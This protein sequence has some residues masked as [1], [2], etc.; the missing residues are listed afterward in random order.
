MHQ[1]CVKA[2]FTTYPDINWYQDCIT[3]GLDWGYEERC[4]PAEEHAACPE[5]LSLCMPGVAV[6]DC[7]LSKTALEFVNGSQRCENQYVHFPANDFYPQSVAYCKSFP[8]NSSMCAHG[9]LATTECPD[10][11]DEVVETSCEH[12]EDMYGK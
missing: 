4:A 8:L 5:D 6:D 1:L 2:F 11:L 3:D 10:V 9:F 7:N 12:S